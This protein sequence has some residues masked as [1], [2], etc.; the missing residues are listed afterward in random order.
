MKPVFDIASVQALLQRGIDAG[1]W[2]LEQLDYPSPDYERN[3]IEARKNKYFGF[4]FIPPVPYVNPLRR[5]ETVEVVAANVPI[6]DLASAVRANKG[7]PDV[8]L[9]QPLRSTVS[10]ER[11]PAD[12]CGEQN[13]ETDRSDHGQQGDMGAE[14]QHAAPD[15]GGIRQPT[16]EPQPSSRPASTAP[17]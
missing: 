16:L 6:P 2:T 10:G 3:L 15:A 1:H 17:W 11:H 7:Q 12:W 5:S 9:P 4:D 8:D 14:G 13:R